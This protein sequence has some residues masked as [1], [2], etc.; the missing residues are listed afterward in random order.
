M[1][2]MLD[3]TNIFRLVLLYEYVAVKCVLFVFGVTGSG[4]VEDT[5]VMS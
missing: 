1:V 4:Y 5:T 2:D 3:H